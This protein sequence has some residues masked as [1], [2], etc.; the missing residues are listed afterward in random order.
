MKMNQTR[1]TG[2]PPQGADIVWMLVD[3]TADGPRQRALAHA[4]RSLI[5]RQLL[6]AGTPIPSSRVLAA[7][8]GVSRTTAELAYSQLVAEGYL[9]RA[10]RRGT[11][12]ASFSPDA[13]LSVDGARS[14]TASRRP[15]TTADGAQPSHRAL[16][17]AG[18]DPTP[19]RDPEGPVRPFRSGMPST[20]PV[21]VADLARR[22]ARAWRRATPAQLGYGD[23]AGVPALRA[24]IA[25]HVAV[26][27]GVR[28]TA[29]Q[30]IVT[31]GAQQALHLAALLAIDPG[32]SVWIEDPGYLGAR[33]ALTAAGARLV[34]M[35][36]DAD[37]LIVD[38]AVRRAPRA[39][40]AYVS[41]S[42]Q[43][44]L[45]CTMSAAR[46]HALL[47]WA[48][49]RGAWIIE[50]DYDSEF[51]YASKPL[52]ALQGL[53]AAGR[54]L[55]VGT[56]SKTLVPALRLGYL[57]VPV[58]LVRVARSLQAIM[59]RHAA[60]VEQLALAELIE[61]G[62]YARH[63]RRMRLRYAERQASLLH[64]VR[65]A[66]GA[67]LDVEPASAGLHLVGWLPNGVSD[68]EIAA[69][70]SAAG[71]DLT[72]ISP[73]ALR[74]LRRGGLLLGYAAFAPAVLRRAARRLAPILRAGV[75]KR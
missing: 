18:V 68:V 21:L 73:M 25:D 34:P 6:A 2:R 54:V 35:D 3:A 7:H 47:A 27:R 59:G 38:A 5:D 8:L 49:K 44:P 13:M 36:V 57:I 41:P 62:G 12:V 48:A 14:S 71:F 50:D 58:G 26:A 72:P 75:T 19:R 43:Y 74:P 69:R 42:H 39:R 29:A 66:C 22:V 56:F 20:D 61:D 28:A 52:P 40:A 10:L 33:A 16:R 46:R 9:T 24:A 37:G 45:G 51:R 11:F 60:A 4:L 31:V 64:A 30:V 53:D 32:D 23:P 17:L 63:I 67:W 55:Y 15:R 1:N 65:E 70:A